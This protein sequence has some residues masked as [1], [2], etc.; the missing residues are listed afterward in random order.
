MSEKFD[1]LAVGELLGDFIGT[2]LSN[3]LADASHFTRF[4]GGSPSNLAAN[5]SKLGFS[6][7]V[8]SCVGNENLGKFLIDEVAKSGVNVSHIVTHP[9]QP[10]SIVLVA[11]S[12]GSPD[13]IPYRMADCELESEH[14]SDELLRNCKIVHTTS[15]PLSRNPSQKTML[16]V[17]KRASKLNC[18]LSIDFNYAERVWPDRAE[19]AKVIKQFLAFGAMIKLSEDDA[20]RFYNQ[21]KAMEDVLKDFHSWGASLICFTKGEKGSFISYNQGKD[22]VE[23][24]SQKIEVKDTTGAGDA[25][26]AGFLAAKLCGESVPNCAKAAANL[27]AIKLKTVGPI[28][29][30]VRI[31]DIM[32]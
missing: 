17:A 30:Q 28:S 23:I 10:T 2:E 12:T 19:A 4:Q 31:E 7:S 32:N 29:D 16:D 6:T 22:V 1:L 8:V 9:Y 11:R 15:W 26:W 27:A 13:F 14:I 21:K 20:Q 5:L 24:P 3:S 18:E 25:Y